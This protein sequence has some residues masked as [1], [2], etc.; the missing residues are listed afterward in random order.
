MFSM[1]ATRSSHSIKIVGMSNAPNRET[2]QWFKQH[3]HGFFPKRDAFVNPE[4]IARWAKR[5]LAPDEWWAS[6]QSLSST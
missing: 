2:V 5:L 3:A 1:M 6:I 4:L